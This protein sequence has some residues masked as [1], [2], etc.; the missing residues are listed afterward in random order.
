VTPLEFAAVMRAF[1]A[2]MA[3]T[4][5]VLLTLATEAFDDDH[6]TFPV[7]FVESWA[8]AEITRLTAAGVTTIGFEDRT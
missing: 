8:V 3:V 2:A 5:P 7:S 6:A 4:K 1:P